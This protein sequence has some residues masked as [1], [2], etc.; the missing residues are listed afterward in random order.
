MLGLAIVP[1][2]PHDSLQPSSGYNWLF[3]LY[4]INDVYRRLHHPFHA[5]KRGKKMYCWCTNLQFLNRNTSKFCHPFGLRLCIAYP[6]ERVFTLVDSGRKWQLL[7]TRPK[8]KLEIS[9]LFIFFLFICLYH[10]PPTFEIKRLNLA[11]LDNKNRT[12]AN[13]QITV[14]VEKYLRTF[15][16]PLGTHFE[17]FLSKRWSLI[18]QHK[19]LSSRA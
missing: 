9:A 1:V 18:G 15:Y 2:L 13:N 16:R 8:Y 7:Q 11:Q 4:F 3:H 17:L 5:H 19:M 10:Q 6:I 12:L 14:F